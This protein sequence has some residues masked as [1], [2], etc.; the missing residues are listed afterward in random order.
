MK[1]INVQPN[2]PKEA[3]EF[4]KELHER[5]LSSS[6]IQTF[7]KEY[8][9]DEQ[10][11]KMHAARFSR[12]LEETSLCI[13]CQGLFACR[14]KQ[15]GYILN[16]RVENGI[17]ENEIVKCHY[18]QEDEKS[19]AHL[20][21]FVVND[22]SSRLVNLRLRDFNLDHESYEYLQLFDFVSSWVKSPTFKT[23]YLFGSPGSGKTYLLSALANEIALNNQTVAFVHVP[24]FVSKAKT[25]FDDLDA[26]GNLID[27]VKHADVVIFDDIGAENIT[28]WSRDELIFPILNY[29]LESK[30]S[31]WFTSNETIDTLKQHYS[32]DQKGK[33]TPSKAI[34]MVERIVG[35]ADVFELVEDNRR[36]T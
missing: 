14:Q 31:I 18:L 26:M 29:R 32:V 17:L 3:L 33:S 27:D 10:F 12:W 23:K 15:T 4:Q 1:R 16:L 7:M 5:V 30:K 24:S 9:V 25:Y 13:G 35:C 28:A 21:Y 2:L 6:K 8:N 11:I 19:K 34:R 20:R 22:M 36:N